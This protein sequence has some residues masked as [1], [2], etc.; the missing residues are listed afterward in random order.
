MPSRVSP[1][2]ARGWDFCARRAKNPVSDQL[3]QLERKVTQFLK[4]AHAGLCNSSVS[5]HTE[6]VRASPTL[7]RSAGD[8]QSEIYLTII[9]VV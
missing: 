5:N 1:K 8:L 3:D 7:F 9:F 2:I 4:L 6:V